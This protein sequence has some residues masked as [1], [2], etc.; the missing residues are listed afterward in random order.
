VKKAITHLKLHRANLGKLHQL[1]AVAAE[2]QRVV[3]AYVDWLV[4]HQVRQ[5]N[6][7]ADIPAHDVPTPLSDRWQRC[8][9]Q[10]TCGIVQS[11]SSNERQNPPV[12]RHVCIQANANVVVIEPSKTPTFDFWL[13]ISTL[14]DGKPVRVPVSLYGRA[15][16]ALAAFPTLCTGVTLNRRDGQW[17]ATFIVACHNSKPHSRAVIGIDTGMT[18]LVSTSEGRRYGHTSPELRRR[19]EHSAEKRRRKHKLNICTTGT[20]SLT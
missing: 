16:E 12:L 14:T 4:A 18:N 1:D 9:W 8:A 7:Y 19:V 5:P 3:Q 6:P 10:Q 11:W 17:Y 2:H 15:K 20:G 13:R